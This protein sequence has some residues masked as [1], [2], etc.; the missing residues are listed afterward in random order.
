MDKFLKTEITD[1]C[2]HLIINNPTKRNA[3]NLS[4][5]KDLHKYLQTFSENTELRVLVI[6]GSGNKAFSAGADISEF[7]ELRS[8]TS[9][10]QNYEIAVQNALISLKNLPLVS[11][12]MI[13]GVAIGGGAEIAMECD[14]LIASKRSYFGITPAKLGIGYNERDVE[15]LVKHLGP[16]NA[17]EILATGR[18]YSADEALSLGWVRSV[19]E[20]SE[21][22]EEVFN[23][24][25][26]IAANAPLTV[27]A[28]KL[29]IKEVLKPKDE[30]DKKYCEALVENCFQSA[31][32]R[33]GQDAFRQKRKPIF[34]GI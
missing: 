24:A 33:E 3:I 20:S 16:K 8:T 7:G 12:A 14:I 17:L 11:I 21:L 26:E 10:R 23:V 19:V 31:D 27:K 18:L 28:A 25:K 2:V 4:M 6:S 13:D 34:R 29:M 32:C 5:W 9:G 1:H 15:R 30:R 22:E